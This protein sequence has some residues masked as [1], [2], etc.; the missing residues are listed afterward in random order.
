MQKE[1]KWQILKNINTQPDQYSRVFSWRHTSVFDEAMNVYL[2][3]VMTSYSRKLFPVSLDG[4]W[5]ARN[6][7][8]VNLLWR[9]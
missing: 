7:A 2:S 9:R 6:R 3:L 1:N 5:Y 8:A 4:M